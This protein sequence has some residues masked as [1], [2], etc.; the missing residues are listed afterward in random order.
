[1][2]LKF[3]GGYS[4]IPVKFQNRLNL[5]GVGI[6]T[7]TQNLVESQQSPPGVGIPTD[8]R[9]LVDFAIWRDLLNKPH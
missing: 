2:S 6:P 3:G 9:N 7:N 4:V 1:M 8:A 5:L